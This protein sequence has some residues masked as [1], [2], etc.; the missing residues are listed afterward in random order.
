MKYFIIFIFIK[1][2]FCSG[3]AVSKSVFETKFHL[4]EIKNEIINEAKIR[5][6]NKLKIISINNIFEKILSIKE[7]KRLIRKINLENQINYLIKNIIIENE[8]ISQNIYKADIKINFDHNEIINLL[9]VNKI[10]YS[11]N[12]S[13]NFLFIAFE[14]NNLSVNGLTNNNSFY[15]YEFNTEDNLIK[16]IIPELSPNDRFILPY[17]KILN[18]NLLALNNISKKYHTDFIFLI[19]IKHMDREVDLEINLFSKKSKSLTF[20]K[21]LIVPTNKNFHKELF[22]FLNDWWKIKNIIDNSIINQLNCKI[23]NSNIKELYL[24]NSKINLVS[25]VRSNIIKKIQFQKN[26]QI[27]SFYGSFDILLFSF[28][29]NNVDIKINDSNECIIKLL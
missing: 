24:I 12:E 5:E 4:I 28:L 20:L 9:R 21:K 3:I 16:F 6:I 29:I 17:N 18:K 26:L 7:K 25:Q 11:D 2:I 1:I 13:P 14:E 10:N 15:N 8:F 23:Y 22:L 27:I 19:L